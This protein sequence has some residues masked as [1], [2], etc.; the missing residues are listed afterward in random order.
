MT[1]Y[2]DYKRNYQTITETIYIARRVKKRRP[3]D[4]EMYV[5]L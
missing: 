2:A 5:I 3:F 4:K 1:D